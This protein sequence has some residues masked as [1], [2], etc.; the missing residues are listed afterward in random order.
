M[1][2]TIIA[3]SMYGLRYLIFDYIGKRFKIDTTK[4]Y[5]DK[6]F[7]IF[8]KIAINFDVLSSVYLS[9]YEEI[10]SNEIDLAQITHKDKILVIGGGTLPI[11][12]VLYARH[13]NALIVSIDKDPQAIKYSQ[14]YIKNQGLQPNISIESAYGEEFPINDFTLIVVVYGIRNAKNV[15]T[16]ISSKMDDS[17]RLLFRT[18]YDYEKKSIIED[19]E[20]SDIFTINTH[21]RSASLGQVDTFLLTKK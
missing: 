11:T 3:K 21:I 12:P 19:F 17:A 5:M 16:Y 8:E 18:T 4:H 1:K 20:L 9:I 15:L 10:V 13:T 6:F 14:K 7:I 2:N